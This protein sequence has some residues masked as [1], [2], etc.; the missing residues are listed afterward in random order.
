MIAPSRRRLDR[1]PPPVE[2]PTR[3]FISIA[4]GLIGMEMA[5]LRGRGVQELSPAGNA[6]PRLRAADG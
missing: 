4:Y 6:K 2:L 3:L 5:E 1:A